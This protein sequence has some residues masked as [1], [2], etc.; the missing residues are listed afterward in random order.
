MTNQLGTTNDILWKYILQTKGQEYYLDCL[1]KNYKMID[2]GLQLVIVMT[3]V[4]GLV[5]LFGGSA[6]DE[7]KQFLLILTIFAQVITLLYPYVFE[8]NKRIPKIGILK[9]ELENLFNEMILEYC[10][11]VNNEVLIDKK[12]LEY[13]VNKHSIISQ[14]CDEKHFIPQLDKK[15]HTVSGISALEH[16]KSYYFL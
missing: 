6:S 7:Y 8:Y 16:I 14:K 10:D 5:T 3:T 13:Y 4:Y 15:Y 1:Y 11:N 2:L 9:S 12:K